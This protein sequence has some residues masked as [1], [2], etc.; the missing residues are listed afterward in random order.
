MTNESYFQTA[1]FKMLSE[2]PVTHRQRF[3]KSRVFKYACVIINGYNTVV[4]YKSGTPVSIASSIVSAALPLVLDNR[5]A[6]RAIHQ[7]DLLLSDYTLFLDTLR[8]VYPP[9]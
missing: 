2:I 3:N 7:C 9:R 6:R 8:L 1:M 5:Y 4:V